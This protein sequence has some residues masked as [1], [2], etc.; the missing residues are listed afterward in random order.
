ML[1][2]S[3]L[4]RIL[5]WWRGPTVGEGLVLAVL[6]RVEHGQWRTLSILTTI[7]SKVSRMTEQVQAIESTLDEVQA[8]L[9]ETKAVVDE[10]KVTLQTLAE[11]VVAAGE[12][13]AALLRIKEKAAQV[14]ADLNTAKET[15]KAAEDAADDPITPEVPAP[16]ETPAPDAT[17][18]GIGLSE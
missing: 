3:V 9:A 15:L 10:T 8:A 5:N 6:T 7:N 2:F 11:A 17:T 18:T 4:K 16:V 1:Q 12:D 14:L 13:K